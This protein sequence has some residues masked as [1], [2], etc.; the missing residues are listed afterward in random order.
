MYL[1]KIHLISLFLDFKNKY[2]I[3]IQRC[4]LALLI[5]NFFGSLLSLAFI[6]LRILS[7][8]QVLVEEDNDCRFR[9][10]RNREKDLK[11]STSANLALGEVVVRRAEAERRASE[12]LN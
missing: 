8:G 6:L 3:I 7:L 1:S 12:R 11:R 5:C 10:A 2:K 9:A 4:K